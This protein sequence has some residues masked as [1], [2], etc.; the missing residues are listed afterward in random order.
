MAKNI[1]PKL[2]V[3][4]NY[5]KL[6]RD[7]VFLVPEYQREY[8]W[9]KNDCDKL[10][11]NILEFADSDHRDAYFFGTV[12]VSC[13]NNDEVF[14]LIDGQQRTTT[15]LL[16]LK[17]LLI[18]INDAIMN[19]SSHDEESE[20]LLRGL[21]D[22]LRAIMAILYKAD[23]ESVAYKPD[24]ARDGKL[25]ERDAILINH[26]INETYPEDLAKI[27][28]AK[29][30]DTALDTA[31][32]IPNR[33]N[34]NKYTN[35]FRNFKYFYEAAKN[36]SASQL[37]IFTKTMLNDCEIIEIKSWQVEQAITMFNSLNADGL[38]LSDSNIISAKLYAASAAQDTRDEFKAQ[39]EKLLTILQK[40]ENEGVVDIDN[41]LMQEMYYVRAK[42]NETL[43]SKGGV[44]VTTP[45]LRR[46]FEDEKGKG[47][48]VRPTEF[49]AD[50]LN[51][52][53]TWNQI[54][55]LPV[56]Q[57]MLK[58]NDNIKL[59][60]PSFLQRQRGAVNEAEV[61]AIVE[62]ML[63]LFAV[64]ELVEAGYSS[65]KFK[66][67]MFEVQL[68]LVDPAVTL[69]EIK[70]TFNTHIHD[71]WAED[72]LLERLK[73]YDGNTLIYLNEY[74]FAKE[75]GREFGLGEKY[76]IEHIMPVSG[77]KLDSIRADAL[78]QSVEEFEIY[79]NKLG[80]KILLEEDINRKIGNHWF[81]DKIM[82]SID[83]RA[84]YVGSKYPLAT[85]L[86]EKYKDTPMPIWTKNEI[87]AA[88]AKAAER[89]NK[90]IF[91]NA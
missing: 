35:F 84:G 40:L 23:A 43:N 83:D 73:D 12:I 20:E 4:G 76:D 75:T 60:L 10:W 50:L 47:L 57:V 2:E 49:C 34:D 9:G 78:V 61:T 77:K 54:I 28:R 52:A 85:A 33:K 65:K 72:D 21:Q 14:A 7:S 31:T 86:V 70:A 6:D 5:L 26:S 27:L 80:N 71:S 56:V 29:D 53:E 91:N 64:L 67:F 22:R 63:R 87:V 32:R 19:I 62:L 66:M 45:G 13:E 74:L 18:N 24:E 11:N 79:L 69:E 1:E 37:N 16:L 90:F 58:F 44:D 81:R 3:I 25:Y 55:D 88:T 59:F 42:N 48:I 51:I 17:A 82:N 89:I 68:K 46:Y 30:F 8:T 39:W 38:P 36:L 41:V 15:F